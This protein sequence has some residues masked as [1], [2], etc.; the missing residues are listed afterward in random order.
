VPG[1]QEATT[2]KP[3]TSDKPRERISPWWWVGMA[4]AGL[5]A[6]AVAMLR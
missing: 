2:A 5:G 1:R 3:E 6:I 4:V